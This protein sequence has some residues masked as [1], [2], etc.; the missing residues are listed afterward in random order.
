MS[1]SSITHRAVLLKR[2][3]MILIILAGLGLTG[4]PT[5]AS[6]LLPQ[7]RFDPDGY[8]YIKGGSPRG[9]EEFDH[10]QLQVTGKI[11]QRPTIESHVYAQNGRFYRCATLGEFRTH[12]SGGGITFEFTTQIVE[13]VSYQFSGKFDS[14]CVLAESEHGPEDVVAVGRLLKFKNG[15]KKGA[16]DV[17]LTYSVSPRRQTSGRTDDSSES[18]DAGTGREVLAILSKMELKA[19]T[20]HL[21]NGEVLVSD[22]IRFEVVEPRELTHVTVT[23]YYQGAPNVQGRRL[24]VGDFVRFELPPE[25]QRFGI[26]LWDL[27]GLR[28]RE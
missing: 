7:C 24:Q 28:F 1:R 19:Y 14:I 21:E 13:G 15:K 26:L 18:A 4:A 5:R 22:I 3:L 12:S 6:S 23:A 8:F 10:I 2:L 9:F 25:P 16:A 20:D 17:E 27:K 11:G